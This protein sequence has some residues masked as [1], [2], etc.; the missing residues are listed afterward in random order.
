MKARIVRLNKLLRRQGARHTSECNQLHGG[1][2]RSH[3]TRHN[4][5]ITKLETRF[6]TMRWIRFLSNF[7]K[8]HQLH[9]HFCQSNSH[10]WVCLCGALV[11]ARQIAAIHLC[12]NRVQLLLVCNGTLKIC[13][14]HVGAGLIRRGFEQKG[15]SVLLR[16]VICFCF[17]WFPLPESWSSWFSKVSWKQFSVM[18]LPFLGWFRDIWSG[19]L[20][21]HVS[22]LA[23]CLLLMTFHARIQ[24]GFVSAAWCL[25]FSGIYPLW[26]SHH[27]VLCQ[28]FVLNLD[29]SVNPDGISVI[30]C[31]PDSTSSTFLTI[32]QID[33]RIFLSLMLKHV[34]KCRILASSAQN[35]LLNEAADMFDSS[36]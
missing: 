28:T 25:S 22:S 26:F 24:V 36:S 6:Y 33:L 13:L 27:S 3:W 12:T 15:K 31:L 23:F 19:F 7:L 20:F 17:R 9:L 18:S 14:W 8:I 1:K 10:E 32:F 2:E 35:V 11:S 21:S 34:D 29:V 5:L 16:T 4:C 30:R